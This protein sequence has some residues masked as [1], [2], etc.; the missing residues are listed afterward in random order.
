MKEVWREQGYSESEIS[1]FIRSAQKDIEA[2]KTPTDIEGIKK[3]I[4]AEATGTAAELTTEKKPRSLLAEVFVG[5]FFGV[6]TVTPGAHIGVHHS[7]FQRQNRDYCEA[8][9]YPYEGY[10]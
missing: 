4:F 2:E 7:H 9:E 5:P 3:R 8:V 10:I 1:G 6:H